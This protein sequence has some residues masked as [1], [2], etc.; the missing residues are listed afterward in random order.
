MNK[1]KETKLLNATLRKL[2]SYE[3]N[4]NLKLYGVSYTNPFLSRRVACRS[5]ALVNKL[6]IQNSQVNLTLSMLIEKNAKFE[7]DNTLDFLVRYEAGD[8]PGYEQSEENP[9][10]LDESPQQPITATYHLADANLALNM[11]NPTV[12]YREFTIQK[13]KFT[14]VYLTERFDEVIDH[15]VALLYGTGGA[16]KFLGKFLDKELTP[17]GFAPLF[18]LMSDDNLLGTHIVALK[19]ESKKEGLRSVCVPIEGVVSLMENMEGDYVFSTDQYYFKLP[20]ASLQDYR[21]TVDAV[22]GGYV[23]KLD[24]IHNSIELRVVI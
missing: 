5:Q 24:S 18:E 12:Q 7:L 15:T 6:D 23:L 14:I 17:I 1:V 8:I 4:D 13:E 20:Y 9:D 2:R 10:F 16:L 21:M 11:K 19:V 22:A 3:E